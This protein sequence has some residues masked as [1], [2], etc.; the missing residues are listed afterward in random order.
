MGGREQRDAQR[1]EVRS[2]LA[3]AETK[4]RTTLSEEDNAQ[5]CSA[6]P[7][8]E[9]VWLLVSFGM[10]PRDTN[11]KCHVLMFIDIT[12]AHPQCTMRRQVWVQLPAE[13][14]RSEEE[15]ACGLLLRSVCGLRDAGMNLR[16]AHASSHGQAWFHLRLADSLRLRAS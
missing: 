7:L 1:P 9:A 8:Y 10:S 5:T 4:R 13:D 11:E 2:R 3:V 6:T 15:G 12:R 16:A 14:P